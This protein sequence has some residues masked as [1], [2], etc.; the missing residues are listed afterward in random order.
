MKL[1]KVFQATYFAD[2]ALAIRYVDD[3]LV[4]GEIRPNGADIVRHSD[5]QQ[6]ASDQMAQGYSID[7][8][9]GLDAIA[10]PKGS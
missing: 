1:W 8:H 6:W 3:F 9:D 7:W 5:L 2:S 10:F 4:R